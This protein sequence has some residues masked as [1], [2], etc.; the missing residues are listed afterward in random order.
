MQSPPAFV[1]INY[2]TAGSGNESDDSAHQRSVRFSKLA[3]VRHLAEHEAAE[4]FYAR[5]SYQ[6]SLQAEQLAFRLANRLSPSQT[7]HLAITFCLMVH[8]R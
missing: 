6:A 1:P 4:A 7:A 5:L 8:K 2:D 3:E